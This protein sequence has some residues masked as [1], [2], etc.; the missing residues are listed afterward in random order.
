MKPIGQKP[1]RICS[2]CH[3]ETRVAKSPRARERR[4]TERL[5]AED[6][7]FENECEDCTCRECA[8]PPG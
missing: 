1:M 2:C 6:P 3:S 8:E 5:V 4:L 7:P